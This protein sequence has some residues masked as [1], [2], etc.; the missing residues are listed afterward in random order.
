MTGL[1]LDFRLQRVSA[2]V[3]VLP[4][5]HGLAARLRRIHWNQTFDCGSQ[6]ERGELRSALA[7]ASA[8]PHG[9][10]GGIG[11]HGQAKRRLQ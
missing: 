1:S 5:P 2:P 4:G 9:L 8:R 10:N 6:V 3:E 11:T 7:A